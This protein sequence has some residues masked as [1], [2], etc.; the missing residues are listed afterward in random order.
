VIEETARLTWQEGQTGRRPVKEKAEPWV[1][2]ALRVVKAH[3][4]RD[5]EKKD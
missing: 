5:E 4:V 2:K 3:S 1:A